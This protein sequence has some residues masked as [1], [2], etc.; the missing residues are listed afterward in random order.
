MIWEGRF[1]DSPYGT[2]MTRQSV[3]PEASPWKAQEM[4][5]VDYVTSIFGMVFPIFEKDFFPRMNN[6]NYDHWVRETGIPDQKTQSPFQIFPQES[7]GELSLR[8]LA[9][10]GDLKVYNI[11]GKYLGTHSLYSGEITR[12]LFP[13][14][15]IYLLSYYS[16]GHVFT[17]KVYVDC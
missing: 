8:L 7:K 10:P 3:G 17:E 13:A 15:G 6:F 2:I 12:I 4:A 11:Q 14:S 16:D 9:S 1:I 5:L